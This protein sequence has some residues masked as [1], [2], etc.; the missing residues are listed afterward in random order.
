ML[1]TV[2]LQVF[3]ISRPEIPIRHGFCYIPEAEYKDFELYNIALKVVNYNISI[4][5]EYSLEV[6]RE[7][8]Y[9]EA[10]W[11]GLEVIRRLVKNANRLFI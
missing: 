3:L 7:E 8:R 10:G 2:R 5:I 11:P 4:F 9:I 6:I 1:K